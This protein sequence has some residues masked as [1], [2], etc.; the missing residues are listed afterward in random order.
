[1]K[2]A[3]TNN[4]PIAFADDLG[5]FLRCD[6]VMPLTSSQLNSKQHIKTAKVPID[7]DPSS[8]LM[9]KAKKATA[10]MLAGN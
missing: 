7:L 2:Y 1:M 9:V 4:V 10:I 5:E 3:R 8:Q 6:N